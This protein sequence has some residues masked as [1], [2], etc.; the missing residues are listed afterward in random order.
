MKAVLNGIR[1]WRPIADDRRL[2]AAAACSTC[3]PRSAWTG[4]SLRSDAIAMWCTWKLM[5]SS[6]GRFGLLPAAHCRRLPVPRCG[7][8][9]RLLWR[10]P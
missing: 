2:L 5:I 9:A 6:S 4:R 8:P 3:Q 7:I 1:A 10:G